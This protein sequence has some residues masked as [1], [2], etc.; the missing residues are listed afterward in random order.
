MASENK[1]NGINSRNALII[2]IALYLNYLSKKNHPK[3]ITYMQNHK[4]DA[5][6]DIL[7]V[8]LINKHI[9]QQDAKSLKK[10]CVNFAKPPEDA[11][12]G[13]L[14]VEFGFLTQSNM[15]LAL[16]E[17]KRLTDQG[18]N[19]ML[20]D[21]LVDAGM[22]SEKQRSL[23][24]Q[25]QKLK[26]S[27]QKETPKKNKRELEEQPFENN[28]VYEI[29]EVEIKLHIQRDAFKAFVT[30]TEDF[31]N[32]MLI[33]DL[34]YLLEKNNIIYG[35][36]DDD[37]LENFIKDKK[38]T[39]S[40]FEIAEGL[41][42][43]DGI[44]ARFIYMFERDYL[45][46]GLLKDDGAI[47]FKD[48][49]EIPFVEEKDILAEKIPPKTGK[50]GVSIFGEAIPCLIAEDIPFNLGQNVSLSKDELKVIA[51]V[52]GNPKITQGGEISVNDAYFIKGDVDYKTGHVKFDKNVFIAGSI[53]NGFRVEAITV[54][55][56][57]CDGGI[58]KAKGDVFIQNGVTESTIEA[59]GDIKAGFM[60]RSKAACTGGMTIIKEIVDTE[61]ILE[62]EFKIER[63]RVFSSVVTAKGGAKIFNLG[64]EKAKPSTITVGTSDYF[65]NQINMIDKAIERRQNALEIKT[66]EKN[67]TEAALNDAI[68][69][70]KQLEKS[71]KRTLSIMEEMEKN[72]GDKPDEKIELFQKG[73]SEADKKI[74]NL[75][76]QKKVEEAL[77]RKI[78]ND[79]KV[80][81]DS[82]KDSVKEKFS[83][84]RLNQKTTSKP[85]LDVSGT[86]FSGT[87]VNGRYTNIILSKTLTHSR[88]MEV[89]S[90]G[91]KTAKR[92][93]EMIITDF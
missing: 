3:L 77:F 74:H 60:H 40:Y 49:G 21:C 36:V 92:N 55:A 20:G 44:D 56:N 91:D 13:S 50:A 1:I 7:K 93:W 15:D 53:K 19:I 41:A 69:K 2:K 38:G 89:N 12:F 58:I 90:A 8:M 57:T 30:K 78:K 28:N 11:R 6:V 22:L 27:D 67:N 62:G 84:K 76:S 71:K 64:S 24:L 87:K 68:E 72:A 61:V 83:L 88:I 79:I 25:K 5:E 46:A 51:D 16:E 81:A 14:C 23:V 32:A 26:I 17:Q 31:D 86:I 85:I 80:Y 35:I 29:D 70:L 34:K 54:V 39:E 9:N 52:S 10:I 59:K 33:S 48:R 65:E 45:K 47:D 66:I 4:S 37:R 43:I 42:P 73:L 75:K 63:G 18:Q 82:V